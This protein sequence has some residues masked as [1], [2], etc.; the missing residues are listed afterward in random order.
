LAKKTSPGTASLIAAIVF[1]FILVQN[2]EANETYYFKP[3]YTRILREV[4]GLNPFP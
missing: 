1:V 3:D 4:Y 2:I